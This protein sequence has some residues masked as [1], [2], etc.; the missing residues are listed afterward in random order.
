ML[1][2]DNI[3]FILLMNNLPNEIICWIFSFV[4]KL[5]LM[6]FRRTFKKWQN[7]IEEKFFIEPTVP[8]IERCIIT[9]NYYYFIKNY[10]PKN[11]GEDMNNKKCDSIYHRALA[12]STN[13]K[14][15]TKFYFE[16]DVKKFVIDYSKEDP[17]RTDFNSPNYYASMAANCAAQYD[18]LNIIQ[19]LLNI[20][21]D[22]KYDGYGPMIIAAGNGSL[23]TLKYL[24]DLDKQTYNI[25]MDNDYLLITAASNNQNDVV[26][27]LLD[28]GA[29][30]NTC[31]S[32]SLIRA[33]QEGHLSTVK[34]LINRGADIHGDNDQALRM[35]AFYGHLDIVKILIENGAIICS[36]TNGNH[37]A[38]ELCHQRGTNMYAEDNDALA[39]SARKGHIEIVK[40]LLDCGADIHAAN[41]NA[42]I[43]SI[44][45]NKFD[46]V[47]LL[48]ER[49]ASINADNEK[50]LWFAAQNDNPKMVR[51]LLNKG[52]DPCINN[53]E[54]LRRSKSMR[55]KKVGSLLKKAIKRKNKANN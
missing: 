55:Y 24:H 18:H 14:F 16:Y 8:S 36:I 4:H 26:T 33:V 40:Y 41:D 47:K 34:L 42:L 12:W 30:I 20:G 25:H 1:F 22:M 19:Y 54:I 11:P 32:L 10:L 31:D 43:T 53:C 49:G 7:L 13:D 48:L 21:V 44:F 45:N 15:F 39:L 27:F 37:D 5:E 3:K 23:K 9:K 51:L 6:S 35:A 46:V 28:N 50:P 38:V 52:A 17:N 29:N 2:T